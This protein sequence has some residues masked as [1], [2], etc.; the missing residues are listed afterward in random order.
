MM[1]LT[2]D[3]GGTKTNFA[4]ITYVN[5]RLEIIQQAKYDSKKLVS[6]EDGVS[7]FLVK[8][9]LWG[10]TEIKAAWFCLAGPV[11]NNICR[12][13]NLDLTVD[14]AVL[15][16]RLAFIPEIGM[17]NDLVALGYGIPLLPDEALLLLGGRV[18]GEENRK[19]GGEALNQ[20]VLAPGTGLGEALLIA[21]QVYPTEGAHVDFA[22][23]LE[24]DLELWRFL[25]RQFGHVSYERLLSGAGLTNIYRYLRNR[26]NHPELF[27]DIL[28]PE[29][30]SGQALE[31]S[32]PVCM[33]ALHTFAR[34]LGAEAGNLALKSLAR[35]GVYLGGGIPPKIKA[36][37]TDG[38]LWAAFIDK[39]RFSQL[40]EE[41]PVHIILEENT[42]V[43]GAARLALS[44]LGLEAE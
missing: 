11:V 17:S 6:L 10:S 32:C 39:G 40:L 43:L 24:D 18:Q 26:E 12:L 28:S 19:N 42:P 7:D 8:S 4:I 20:A 33:Q 13:T 41:I 9:G 5:N 22:P 38:T 14:L 31:Q 44:K 15:K 3:M 35:G 16:K 30:I 1:L 27:P 21:G 36:K 34:L 37:L 25:H 23:V 29:E 2:G